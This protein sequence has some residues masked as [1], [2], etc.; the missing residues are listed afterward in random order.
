MK[1]TVFTIVFAGILGLVHLSLKFPETQ[2]QD[3]KLQFTFNIEPVTLNLT[4][5]QFAP[6]FFKNGVVFGNSKNYRQENSGV[7]PA[8]FSSLLYFAE[9]NSDHSLKSPQKIKGKGL[10]GFETSTA[11]F[12]PNGTD[13]ILTRTKDKTGKTNETTQGL[14]FAS[15]K[16]DTEVGDLEAFAHNFSHFDVKQA[17]LSPDGS[18]LFFVSDLQGGVGG[19]DL[20]ICYKIG[21]NWSRPENL[22]SKVNSIYNESFPFMT[23][24]GTLYFSSAGFDNQTDGTDIFYTR[25]YAGEWLHPVKLPA[26]VNSAKDDFGFIIKSDSYGIGYGYFTSNRNDQTRLFSF[27]STILK[28]EPEVSE[29]LDGFITQS[30]YN[31]EAE[32]SDQSQSVGHE[33]L[34]N[35]IV[36]MNKLFFPQGKWTIVPETGRELEKLVFYMNQNPRLSISIGVHTDS[37]GDDEANLQLSTKRANAIQTFL[38]SREISTS[39]VTALGYGETQLQ[40]YCRNGMN[41]S[42]EMHEQ[43]NRVEIKAT[44]ESVYAVNWGAANYSGYTANGQTVSYDVPVARDIDLQ[45]A[46][47]GKLFYKVTIGPYDRIDNRVFY[48]CRQIDHTLNFEDTP[49]GKFIVLGPFDNMQEAYRSKSYLEMRGISK[50][51]VNNIS[52]PALTRFQPVSKELFDESSTDATF[53]IFVGPFKHVDN[54][55]YHRFANLGTPIHIE[56]SPKGMMIVLGPYKTMNDVEQYKEL[57]K[58]RVSSN[59]TKVVVYNDDKPVEEKQ[60]KNRFRLFSKK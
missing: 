7:S 57:V 18:M 25:K 17:A 11:F 19:T 15:M 47:R 38:L 10:V 48:E 8:G 3:H 46:D 26:P 4:G 5:A 55:T 22:G 1:K 24:D 53:Q 32:Y 23:D 36:G 16:S 14:F 6:A 41:C 13:V 12:S 9:M 2:I 34:L 49:S 31:N 54:N 45:G 59:K 35:G 52:E 58:E 40:N 43:N 27:K 28:N 56:Y 30:Q 50:A 37:R 39:R 20:Y 44:P 21:S 51:K 33:A 42:D 29:E 60:Q